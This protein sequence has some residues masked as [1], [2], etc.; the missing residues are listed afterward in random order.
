MSG[1]PEARLIGVPYDG[2]PDYCTG[3]MCEL[4]GQLN[5][6]RLFGCATH[7]PLLPL[8]DELKDSFRGKDG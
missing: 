2:V 3:S 1:L 5:N 7:P 4:I 8:N 6:G